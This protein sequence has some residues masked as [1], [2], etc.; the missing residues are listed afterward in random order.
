M[1]ITLD[2]TFADFFGNN[3]DT[4]DKCDECGTTENLTVSFGENFQTGK[5][6][7]LCATCAAKAAEL[8]A[9]KDAKN[10]ARQ[11]MYN[12]ISRTDG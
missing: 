3:D 11:N 1:T 10:E 6:K 4:I 12:F 5:S 7:H 8:T 2:D 9:E